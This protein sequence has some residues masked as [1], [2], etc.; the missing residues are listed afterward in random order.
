MNDPKRYK[1]PFGDH[2]CSDRVAM[3]QHYDGDWVRYEDYASVKALYEQAIEQLRAKPDVSESIPVNKGVEE[4]IY[5]IS[6]ILS[7]FDRHYYYKVRQAYDR[8]K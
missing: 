1:P 7:N 6:D 8:N 3:V 2:P 5:A 4:A